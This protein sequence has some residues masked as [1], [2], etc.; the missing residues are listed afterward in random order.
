MR[1]REK[2]NGGRHRQ[3]K[4]ARPFPPSFRAIDI[5][6]GKITKA[7][8][9]VV[10]LRSAPHSRL[11]GLSRQVSVGRIA[12]SRW[13]IRLRLQTNARRVEVAIAIGHEAKF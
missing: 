8:K 1:G 12:S 13:F 5:L 9:T 4:G 10:E 6:C 7:E 11:R 2:K 3:F